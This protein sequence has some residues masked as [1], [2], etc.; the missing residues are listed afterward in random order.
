MA[1][2]DIKPNRAIEPLPISIGTIFDTVKTIVDSGHENDFLAECDKRSFAIVV[3]Q[4]IINFVK[5]YLLDRDVHKG[6]APF[7][8]IARDVIISPKGRCP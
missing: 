6:M 3:N 1:D 7:N 2:D 8:K 5:E 4:E